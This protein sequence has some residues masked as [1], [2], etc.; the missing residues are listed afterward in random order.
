MNTDMDLKGRTILIVDD[1]ATNLG[2]IADYLEAFDVCILTATD[3]KDALETAQAARPDLILLDVMM[4]GMDG[5]EVCQRLKADAPTADIPIIF[6]TALA[7][8][9]ARLEG[10]QAGAVDYITKPIRQE[11]VLACIHKHLTVRRHVMVMD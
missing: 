1:N 10:F 6:M 5:F 11:D 2:V 8:A 7:Q 3:G 4:P 9:E